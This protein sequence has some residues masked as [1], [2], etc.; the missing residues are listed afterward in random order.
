MK[1]WL[2]RIGIMILSLVFILF[3]GKLI[4]EEP[5]PEG[6]PGKDAELLASQMLKSIHKEA[7][8][9][10]HW[11]TWSYK[12]ARD[13]I[14]DRKRNYLKVDWKKNQVWLDLN[15]LKNS[16]VKV[17][18]I[19]TD[20]EE[21]SPLIDKAWVYFCN[22]SFWL[23]APAKIMDDGTKRSLVKLEGEKQGLLVTY[24]SGGVTPG[25]SYLWILDKNARP[26]SFKM[27]V[28]LIP[29]GG[30]EASWEDWETTETEAVISRMHKIAFLELPILNLKTGNNLS[31]FNIPNDPFDVFNK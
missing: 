11:V 4:L 30:I 24:S 16:K 10:T 12:G 18:G 3:V 28:S 13:F 21:A 2:L 22:D 6:T 8:D 19:S 23:N 31:T 26:L 25:D 17:N 7:W 15:D 20:G 27:W 9:N 14:W 5:I 1:K 29:I